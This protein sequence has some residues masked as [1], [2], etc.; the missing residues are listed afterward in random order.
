MEFA[1]LE[2]DLQLGDNKKI[3]INTKIWNASIIKLI[4]QTMP[5]VSNY[6]KIISL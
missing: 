5:I 6:Y 4:L 1:S 2:M 3:C